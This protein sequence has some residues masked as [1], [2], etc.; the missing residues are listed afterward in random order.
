MT[1]NF[2]LSELT[3]SETAAR[4]HI[5]NEPGTIPTQNLKLLCENI[6]QPLR[7]AYRLPILVNS[8]FRS[9]A[10]NAA[11]K[12]AR[13]SQHLLGQA[14]DITARH[15]VPI[16]S[17]LATCYDYH[18]ENKLLFNLIL[19]LNLPF[20]QLIDEKNYSWI[21]VSYGPRNRRQ[22]LHL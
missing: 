14:A 21:H 8:G 19:A 2:T 5:N 16:G 3:R 7:N 12:G 22:V 15:S 1:E 9:A 10:L 20:D 13:N 11:I 17:E 6:L 18:H 4:M